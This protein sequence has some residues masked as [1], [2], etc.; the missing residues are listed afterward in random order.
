MAQRLGHPRDEVGQ[1]GNA[2]VAVVTLVTLVLAGVLVNRVAWTAESINKKAGNIAKTAVPIN[3]ATDAVLN[4]D[5][6]NGLAGSILE[7]AKPLEGKLAEIVRLATSVNGLASSIN[8]SASEVD[9]TAKGINS[10]ASGILE[11]ARSIDRGVVQIN[12][13]LDTTIALAQQIKGDS[14]NILAQARTAHKE[15]ACI[16]RGLNAADDGHCR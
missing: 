15:A 12:A 7:T 16:D 2:V 9:G 10:T 14:G 13:N 1:A 11:V 4:L 6:T 5:T 3:E 8:A